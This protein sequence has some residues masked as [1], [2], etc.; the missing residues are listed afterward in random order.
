M[1]KKEIQKKRTIT[2]HHC[3]QDQT[4]KTLLFSLS[5]LEKG[6]RGDHDEQLSQTLEVEALLFQ[7]EMKV[8]TKL[9]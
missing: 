8:F 7:K 1:Y 5:I 3:K 2:T 9:P 6:S 4:A